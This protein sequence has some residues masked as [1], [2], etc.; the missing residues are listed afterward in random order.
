M[1]NK[2][3]VV[4][5][6]TNALGLV[7]KV[8]RTSWEI[9]P[10]TEFDDWQK[11]GNLLRDIEGSLMWWVGDW[12]AFGEKNYGETYSQAVDATEYG[13]ETI[14]SAKWVAEKF[15]S[16]RR[17]TDLSWGHHQA[18]AALEEKDADSIL[19]RA[20]KDGWSIKD[21]REAARNLKRTGHIEKLVLAPPVG[22]Y[23]CIVIDPPW[24]MEKIERYVAPNQIG[25]DYPTMTEEQL[26]V[27]DVPSMA[28]DDCHL[29][30]WTTH[31]HLPQALRLLEAWGFHYVFTM[32]WHKNGGFQPFGLAQY[33]CEFVLYARRGAPS[34]I[35]TKQFF[36][37]F[38]APRREHSR[39][40]EEFYEVV[41]RVTD[42]PRIDVFSREKRDGFSQYG[43]ETA[44]FAG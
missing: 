40:P 3:S 11:A 35:D 8:T 13:Y 28:A 44:K 39:K 41:G 21:T 27:F 14:R 30:C 23:G 6:E 16:V 1:N 34:F 38:N 22:R 31:K 18:V 32:V 5:A 20:M 15:Q 42:G 10:G 29:F 36:C 26:A 9:P 24:E 37:C 12:L 7:G 19:V 4:T 2:T 17:I 33:N 43:N 25:F